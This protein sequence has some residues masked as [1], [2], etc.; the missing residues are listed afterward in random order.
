[1]SKNWYP[2]INREKCIECSACIKNCRSNV[3]DV[4]KSPVPIVK[5]PDNCHEGCHGCGNVC[6]VGAITYFGE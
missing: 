2:Q 1:M 3:Y 4:E 5:N 6:P